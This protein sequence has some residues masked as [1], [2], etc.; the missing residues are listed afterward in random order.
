MGLLDDAIREHLELKRQHG[1]DPS[2]V[3]RLEHEALGPVRR[4]PFA[5]TNETSLSEE[6][7]DDHPVA[8]ERASEPSEAEYEEYYEE[9]YYDE[10]DADDWGEPFD[11]DFERP[12]SLAPKGEAPPAAPD[13][14]SHDEP[15]APREEETERGLRRWRRSRRGSVRPEKAPRTQAE[16]P[17][18]GPRRDETGEHG[19]E[20]TLADRGA[21]R[22]ERLAADE[23][24]SE[25]EGDVL[26]ETP[27]FLQDAPEHDRLWFEQRPPRDFDFDD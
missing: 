8:S 23:P 19:V 26:E 17:E 14:S 21:R 7:T 16:P 5:P 12:R 6:E 10:E 11:D 15:P 24:P 4:E 27:E 1:A 22:D 18:D 20:D 9:E 2:E 3:D 25:E 13:R